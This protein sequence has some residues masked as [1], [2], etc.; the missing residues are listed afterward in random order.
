VNK[1]K[2]VVF[3]SS[4]LDELQTAPPEA[5]EGA[6]LLERL[7]SDSDDRIVIEYRCDR[8]PQQA[9]VSEELQDVLAVIAD[10]ER[11][12][13]QLLD[14]VGVG[15]G[16]TLEL[17][18]RYG[19]GFDSVDVD[20]A[21]DNGVLVTNT[22]GANSRP[23]AE[24]AVAT[25]MDIAG[26]R[27]PHH[28][29]AALGKSKTGPSRLDISERTLGVVGT[30]AIG[31]TVVELLS[32]F[33]MNILA[34]DPYP[35]QDWA[36]Q[37]DARYVSLEQLCREADFITLHAAA[38]KPIITKQE[39]ARMKPTTTLVNCARGILVD[40]RAAYA[41]VA[42]GKLWGYGLDELW[43]ESDL[44]LAGLNIAASPHVGSDTDRGKARMQLLSA[45]AISEYLTGQT[46]TFSINPKATTNR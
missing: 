34:S 18:A 17:I 30:G 2:V 25:L 42:A 45:Q 8:D 19:V 12:P 10:L 44:P 38:S 39:L 43:R 29:R 4:F 16:G 36:D 9:L 23:T 37:V 24:W 5:G 40:N 35:N 33:H 15:R 22:P 20:A 21:T 46:P 32:G 3:A 7:K 41:A 14:V 31:R 28:E 13:R 26:R 1:K 27:L 11:Y 6:R